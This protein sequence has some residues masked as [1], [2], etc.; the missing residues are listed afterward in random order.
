[1]AEGTK[2]YEGL[3]VPLYGESEIQQQTAATDILTFTGAAS[4]TG[5]FIVAQNSTGAELFVVSSSGLITSAVG[6]SATGLTV[7]V[8]ST[9]VNGITV[10]VTS[11]GAFAD[12]T[13]LGSALYVVG[14][15]KSVL[16]SVITYV[17][18]STGGEVGTCNAFLT[19]HGSKA[20]SYLLSVGASAAGTGAAGANGF[21]T[22]VGTRTYLS[23][24]STAIPIGTIKILAG[25]KAYYIPCLPDTSFA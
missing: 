6:I 5:D 11:T 9:G 19:A 17:S 23:A 8:A 1:M 22:P 12:G 3:S 16:N 14:S 2:T 20:P 25:S 7:T 24:P 15:S 13:A 21:F 4:Q 10:N 18:T